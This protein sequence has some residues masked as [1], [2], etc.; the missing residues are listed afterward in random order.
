MK[1][2]VTAHDPETGEIFAQEIDGDNFDEAAATGRE[3]AR[4]RFRGRPP[5]LTGITE[6][7]EENP[8][9][10]LSL[11]LAGAT[12]GETFKRGRVA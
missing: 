9:G 6:C 7:P 11:M 12:H 4:G 2:F 1:W 3:L 10:P 5:R 8:F